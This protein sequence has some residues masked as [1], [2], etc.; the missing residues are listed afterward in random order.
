MHCYHSQEAEMNTHALLESGFNSKCI[1]TVTSESL[2]ELC[3]PGHPEWSTHW[4]TRP[5]PWVPGTSALLSAPWVPITLTL[6]AAP[7]P[8]WTPSG[9]PRGCPE[10]RVRWAGIR[11]LWGTSGSHTIQSTSE[12]HLG[13]HLSPHKGKRKSCGWGGGVGQGGHA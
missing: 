4:I 5:S 9:C 6:L 2:G 8:Q 1:E 11:T 3:L 12:W 13:L 10:D 7:C